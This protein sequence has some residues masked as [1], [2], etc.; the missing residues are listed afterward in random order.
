MTAAA[1][2]LV[3]CADGSR[4]GAVELWAMG[5]EGEVVEAMLPAF[6]QRHPD[7]DV[8]VQRLPWS[9][10]HEKLLTAYVGGTMPDVFQIG[11]TWIPEM[12]A[13]GALEP[14]DDRSATSAS[15]AR[16]DFFAGIL[17]TN[18]VE[19]RLW[20]L[21]WYVDTR[22]L[23][24]RRDLLQRSGVSGPPATWGQWLD[25]M[26]RVRA[27]A[28]ASS[29][30]IFLPVDEWQTP[31]ILALQRGARLLRDH[32]GRGN[33]SSAE[34]K[35]AMAFYLALYEEGLAPQR[36]AAQI[37][38]LYQEFAAGY[39]TFFITGPWNLRELEKRLP[40]ALSEAWST[41]PMPA[42][43]PATPAISLAGGASLGIAA[44]SRRKEQAWKLLEFLAEPAQQAQFYRASGSLP[45]R[46]SAWS[47]P[48]LAGDARA[49]A[50][51]RQ[52]EHVV[53]TPKIP[54][55]ERI[56]SKITLH[57]ERMVRKDVTLEQG[58]A[59]LDADVDAVLE[60]RRWMMERR[61]R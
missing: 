11:N 13:L 30:A 47:D 3:G 6:R 48:V 28:G 53:P 55:W 25:A 33:F 49:D 34:T 5:S 14:L 26:R 40:A 57:T 45:A 2:I 24:Y 23:F 22:L 41:A 4:A 10:A 17:D 7:I 15:V 36:A 19:G 39:F 61:A 1:T 43:H 18:V 12:V 58:L 31:V 51:R 8:R 16:D 44:S 52:L 27:S 32:D 21:P 54:E 50:F 59:E 29:Y 60:K 37:A 20:S 42:P 35:D 9:A 38:N 46:R 56:A